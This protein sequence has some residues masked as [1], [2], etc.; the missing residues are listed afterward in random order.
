MKFDVNGYYKPTPKNMR[1]F[2]DKLLV[3]SGTLSTI[4]TVIGWPWMTVASV[5][6]G[7]LGKFFTNFFV[8][9]VI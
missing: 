5:V 8:E 4:G 2:G 7:I 3:V 1:K 9:D 6:T